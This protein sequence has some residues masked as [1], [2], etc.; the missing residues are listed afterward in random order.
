MQ[1]V[2]SRDKTT[3]Q[4]YESEEQ[5]AFWTSVAASG[6]THA[7]DAFLSTAIGDKA[8]D[9][10]VLGCGGGRE[11]FV[12]T[13]RGFKVVGIDFAPG[14]L[15]EA[16]KQ[17]EMGAGRVAFVLGDSIDLPFRDSSFDCVIM[18][19]QFLSQFPRRTARRRVLLEASRVLT[20]DGR[21]LLSLF[22]RSLG[23]HTV[24]YLLWR[25]LARTRTRVRSSP[26]NRG[27]TRANINRCATESDRWSRIREMV[28]VNFTTRIIATR[29]VLRAFSLSLARLTGRMSLQAESSRD[30]YVHP[31]RYD[32]AFRPR[33]GFLSL[34][35][36][37]HK[38]LL[39]D[40]RRCGLLIEKIRSGRELNLQVDMPTLVKTFEPLIF[41]SIRRA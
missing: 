31:V 37:T 36:F 4:V 26:T 34:H 1:A 27:A 5:Q 21:L 29:I 8:R 13:R 9:I 3:R 30:V 12:L 19:C 20:P 2:E 32:A 41:C 39:E 10:L 33:P 23:G 24:P 16:A 40:T 14:L 15:R 6:L 11:C 38:E 22:N 17:D 35:L 28:A 18:F 7:E 25:L